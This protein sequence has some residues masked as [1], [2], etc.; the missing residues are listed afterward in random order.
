MLTWILN[1]LAPIVLKFG[2]NTLKDYLEKKAADAATK[3]AI[4]EKVD[5]ILKDPDPVSRAKRMRDLL[6]A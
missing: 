4:K 2:L 6:D 1:L 5:E 3:K